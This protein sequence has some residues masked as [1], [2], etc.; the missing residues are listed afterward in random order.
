MSEMVERLGKALERERENIIGKFNRGSI[1]GDIGK[2]LARVVLTEMRE[3]TEAMCAAGSE[4]DI[5]GHYLTDDDAK[6]CWQAMIDEA[7]RA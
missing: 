1:G 2:R 3:P 4:K 5:S 6:V 7:L